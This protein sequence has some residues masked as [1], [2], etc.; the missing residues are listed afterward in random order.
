M[1][2]VV[3]K[4]G[5]APDYGTF[6]YPLKVPH[7]HPH[8]SKTVGSHQTWILQLIVFLLFAPFVS[9]PVKV[10]ESDK[11]FPWLGEGVKLVGC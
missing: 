7:T 5:T 11:N 8:M 6:I 4:R 9:Q 1:H 3:L 10:V 2:Q